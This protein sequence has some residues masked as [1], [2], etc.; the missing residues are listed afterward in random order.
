MGGEEETSDIHRGAI[1]TMVKIKS[2]TER[3]QIIIIKVA[4]WQD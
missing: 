1:N 4:I 3:I 2:K